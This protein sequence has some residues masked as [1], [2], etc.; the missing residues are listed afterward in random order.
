MAA[1]DIKYF[2]GSIG[3]SL[4][5][6]MKLTRNGDQLTGS[7]FYRK[8]G[9]KI[10]LRGSVDNEG[11]LA[12][13]EFD[14]TGKQTGVFKGIW[15]VDPDGNVALA[16]NWSKPPNEKGS[17]KKT[18]FSI[19]ELPVKFS[20]DVEIAIKQLKENNKQLK[21]TVDAQYPQLV[22]VANPSASPTPPN[23]NFDKFNQYVKSLILSKV[24]EFKKDMASPDQQ[25]AAP[26]DAAGSSL[27][28]GYTVALAQDDFI[29]VD[30]GIGSYYSGAAHPNS[31]SQTV[32]YD[33][34]NGKNLKLSDLFK[35]GAKYLSALST[36][37]ISDLKKTS[38][39]NNNLL[40]D[41]SIESG[42]APTDKNYQNW[43]IKRKGLEIT[44]DAYQVGPY[45]A[46]PQTVLVPYTT[47]KDL[48]APQGPLAQFV[49]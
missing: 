33:L 9:S 48:I 19:H 10:D 13:D 6:E 2:S 3:N 47:L 1:A 36:Y 28:I 20:S 27:D 26:T 14:S 24:S 25:D 41:S 39:A 4:D 18:A 30:F 15:K 40:D 42:A 35:P 37:A 21:F 12:L 46:G 23:P 7:Y 34:R 8:V 44:F 31:Y 43:T 5:L 17:D 38:K 29:S 16:G 11:N 32:N 45:A 49:K 22:A